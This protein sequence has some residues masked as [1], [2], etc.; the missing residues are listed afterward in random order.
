MRE[1]DD[2]A[3]RRYVSTLVQVGKNKEEE[4]DQGNRTPISIHLDQG[5]GKCQADRS[6]IIGRKI[7]V[8]QLAPWVTWD[9]ERVRF[10]VTGDSYLSFSSRRCCEVFGQETFIRLTENKAIM[11]AGT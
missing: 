1:R 7:L 3:Q 5:N 6:H 8:G 2:P 9:G 11:K 4:R 10:L